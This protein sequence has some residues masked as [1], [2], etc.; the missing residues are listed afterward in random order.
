MASHDASFVPQSSWALPHH[1]IVTPVLHS[2]HSV[3]CVV[4]VSLGKTNPEENTCQQDKVLLKDLTA[5]DMGFCSPVFCSPD[6]PVV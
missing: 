5:Q 1:C 3:T 2:C 4:T 6:H